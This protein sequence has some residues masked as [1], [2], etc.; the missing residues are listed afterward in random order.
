MSCDHELAN[1]WVRCGGRNARYITKRVRG[2]PFDFSWG[3]CRIFRLLDI[4]FIVPAQE[5]F[6]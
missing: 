5:D 3:G 2:G 1:E 4:F 6:F